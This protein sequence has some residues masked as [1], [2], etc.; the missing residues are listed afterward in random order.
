MGG[1]DEKM[2]TINRSYLPDLAKMR[3]LV[4]YQSFGWV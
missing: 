1:L 2:G 4:R 3:R